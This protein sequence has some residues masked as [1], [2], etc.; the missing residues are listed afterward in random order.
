MSTHNTHILVLLFFCLQKTIAQTIPHMHRP[1]I[2]TRA[3]VCKLAEIISMTNHRYRGIV[4]ACVQ[5]YLLIIP[6]IRQN[7]RSL[8]TWLRMKDIEALLNALLPS[9]L[10]E[11]GTKQIVRQKKKNVLCFLRLRLISTYNAME[12]VSEAQLESGLIVSEKGPLRHRVF[13]H[14]KKTVCVL[15]LDSSFRQGECFSESS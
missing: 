5:A 12:N 3:V 6:Q 14:T 10:P 13:A 9:F 1:T 11:D 15:K 8:S 7:K 2:V 4:S